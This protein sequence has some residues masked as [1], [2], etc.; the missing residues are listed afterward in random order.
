MRID[1][2]LKLLL[3]IFISTSLILCEQL[4]AGVHTFL[5]VIILLIDTSHISLAQTIRQEHKTSNVQQF[6]KEKEIRGMQQLKFN[7]FM[8]IHKYTDISMCMKK[9]YICI[10]IYEKWHIYAYVHIYIYIH[11]MYIYTHVQRHK[12]TNIIVQV[13]AR[14]YVFKLNEYVWDLGKS[15]V[16]ATILLSDEQLFRKIQFR[17]TMMLARTKLCGIFINSAINQEVSLNFTIDKLRRK[18]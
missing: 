3:S 10:Y 5:P 8:Y 7:I 4:E 16:C 14:K 6:Y 18:F 17:K 11:I 1:I 15:V 2:C 9:I 12:H 13:Y